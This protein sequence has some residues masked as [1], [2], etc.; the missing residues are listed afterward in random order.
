MPSGALYSLSGPKS[1]W[2]AIISVSAHLAPKWT[3]DHVVAAPS[4]PF[5]VGFG[6]N[7][8]AAPFPFPVWAID[9]PSFLFPVLVWR[10]KEEGYGLVRCRPRNRAGSSVT[11]AASNCP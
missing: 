4:I 2:G 7:L 11:V 6:A 3:A 1:D 5:P 10:Q 8:Q 9:A